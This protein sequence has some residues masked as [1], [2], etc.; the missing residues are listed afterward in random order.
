MRCR[1]ILFGV[2]LFSGSLYAED[3]YLTIG[4][5]YRPSGNQASLEKN[6]LF[7]QRLLS[8][9]N[10][11]AKSHGLF[12]AD[13]NSADKDLQVMDR[14]SLPKA[15]RL[16]AEF[17]GSEKDLGL[18]YRNHQIPGV[19]GSSRPLNVELW[20]NETGS[21]MKSGD[22][23]IM[24]VTTHGKGSD[25]RRNA[26]N[27][28]ISLWNNSSLKVSELVGMLDKLPEGVEVIV[29]MV[30][31][32]AG[33]FA[34][35]IFNEGDPQK[36]LSRQKRIGFFATVHDRPAAGCTPDVDE[37]GYVEYSTYFWAAIAGEDRMGVAIEVPDY[38]DDGRISMSEAHAYTVLTADTIDLP[39]KSSEEFL[40]AHSQF[41]DRQNGEL[42]SDT[43][44]YTEVLGFADAV[45]QAVLNGL[46]EQLKL[47]GE[48]RL[49]DAYN[50]SRARTSRTRRDT[51]TGQLRD[52]I[53]SGLKRR[54]PELSNVLNPLSIQLMTTR[55]AEFI[56]AVEGH[57]DYRKYRQAVT[58]DE[59]R[60]SSSEQRVKYERFLRIADNVIL[61]ENLKRLDK[62]ERLA[63]YQS[64]IKAEAQSF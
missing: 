64:L 27:T 50:K 21:K 38:D 45:D 32:H 14:R 9:R 35:F 11:G 33:G 48:D 26:H 37:E 7:Y 8:V 42:L 55:N 17:F 44:E 36:G 63:E 12:F 5:G 18:S 1:I 25:D 16:M 2:L 31:C 52:R 6:V 59:K 4:G 30:Q 41:Q 40:R 34:R 47:S 60:L 54:W 22:R 28:S 51:S 49:N 61:A 57:E 24:Y 10:L 13:G 56:R 29:V 3:F 53:A 46:S 39:V 62:P 58:A 20:L 43:T 19:R 15:S 23:L